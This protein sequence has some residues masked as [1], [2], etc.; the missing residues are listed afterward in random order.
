MDYVRYALFKDLTEARAALEDVTVEAVPPPKDEAIFIVHES[1]AP[2]SE[3]FS[4]SDTARG[5]FWGFLSGAIAG[6]M[7]GLVLAMTGV[8][9]VSLPGGGA[10]GFFCGALIGTLGGGLYGS[11]LRAQPLKELEQLWRNGNVLVTAEVK[12]AEQVAQV[13]RVFKRHHA[14]V[15][16]G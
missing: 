9:P 11:G 5:L 6:L 10:F 13:E 15:V 3:R 4:E 2:R 14:L 12:D 7:L 1:K 16:T 8:L